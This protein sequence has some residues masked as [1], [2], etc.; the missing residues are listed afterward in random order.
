MKNISKIALLAVVA[1][2]PT[3]VIAGDGWTGF[4]IGGNVGYSDGEVSVGPVSFSDN[5]GTYGLQAGYNHDLGNNWVLGGELS[6]GTAEYT[7]LGETG[8]VDT[9]RIKLKAGYD[10]N[11]ALVYGV[12]GYA[13]LDDGDD[14]E[15]GVTYGVGVAFKA[16]DNIIVSGELL[17]DNVDIEGVD[18]DQ[19]SFV[20]GVS[21]KF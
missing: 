20:L 3:L 1:C 14:S 8:D 7:I 2:S 13:N 16:T 9:T 5:S 17:R 12:L 4:Y 18:F 19:T 11:P 21:Y 15:D 10:L 6:Y